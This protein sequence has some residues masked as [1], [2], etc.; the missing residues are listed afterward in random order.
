MSQKDEKKAI[1]GLNLR[2]SSVESEFEIGSS[3]R[4]LARESAKPG[5]FVHYF[6]MFSSLFFFADT[7]LPLNAFKPAYFVVDRSW[8]WWWVEFN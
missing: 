2:F 6:E 5:R 8:P 3:S 1:S 7:P 4:N